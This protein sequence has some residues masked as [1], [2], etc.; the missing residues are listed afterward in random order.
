MHLE[1]RRGEAGGV[2]LAAHR[3][4]AVAG[5]VDR[6]S[7]PTRAAASAGP[8]RHHV[9]AIEESPWISSTRPRDGPVGAQRGSGQLS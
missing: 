5:L 6:A 9:P 3:P 1:H 8:I 2:D 7:R 4:A